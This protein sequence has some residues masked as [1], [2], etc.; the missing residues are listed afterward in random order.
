MVRRTAFLL[1]GCLLATTLLLLVV[2]NNAPLH[3][4]AF[5]SN[6]DGNAEIFRLSP[7]GADL[8]QLTHTSPPPSD[9]HG[10]CGLAWFQ[11]EFSLI[12]SYGTNYEPGD[13]F[14]YH[15]YGQEYR[16]NVITGEMS[17]YEYTESPL[18]WSPDARWKL[19]IEPTRTT[20]QVIYEMYR[21][22]VNSK[23]KQVI[24]EITNWR[25]TPVQ[26]SDDWIVYMDDPNADYRNEIYRVHPDSTHNQRLIPH[27]DALI[28]C[29]QFAI[30][31]D[32]LIV[33]AQDANGA[34]N[35][36]YRVDLTRDTFVIDPSLK[37][38]LSTPLDY[39]SKLL[40]SPQGVWAA[41]WDSESTIYVIH[42]A[43]GQIHRVVQPTAEAPLLQPDWSPDGAWL[44][45]THC[46]EF[47]KIERI[48]PD[49][50]DR[51]RI[52]DGI[53]DDVFPAY[54][55]AFHFG[56]SAWKLLLPGA[57]LVGLPMLVR[58]SKGLL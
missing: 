9:S 49:G 27:S 21:V 54:S 18:I 2:R 45:Y 52:T 46:E 31:G 16:L 23:A 1:G 50:T 26:W 56:W 42:G 7:D 55:P 28:F 51:Q 44:L 11:N 40:A 4:I 24:V 10:Y 22:Q 38:E 30:T 47:C 13:F 15:N 57:I 33:A 35:Q 43:T 5:L 29:D 19:F 8:T 12:T 36:V 34:C 37:I 53:G 48:R 3:F 6:R 39:S 17:P 20:R 14:C 32:W 58:K 25:G 41:F